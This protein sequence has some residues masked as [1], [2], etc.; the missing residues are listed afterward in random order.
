MSQ[1][2][3]EFLEWFLGCSITPFCFSTWLKGPGKLE[4]PMQCMKG[5][6]HL[7]ILPL[8]R[9]TALSRAESLVGK[10]LHYRRVILRGI[11]LLLD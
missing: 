5:N 10:L 2:C 11:F 7:E 4:D 6:K 1:S 9:D 8:R 3:L